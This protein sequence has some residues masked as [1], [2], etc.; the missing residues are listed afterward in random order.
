M[1]FSSATLVATAAGYVG[2]GSP[3]AFTL[4]AGYFSLPSTRAMTG[5]YPFFQ[6]TDRGMATNYSGPGSRR[7]SGPR[8]SRSPTSATWR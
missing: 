8:E 6:G 7:G 2:Y 1:F 3:K 4:R 5:T